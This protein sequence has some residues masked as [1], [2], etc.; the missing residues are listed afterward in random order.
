MKGTHTYG[1][2]KREANGSLANG[3]NRNGNGSHT[4]IGLY[5]T[6]EVTKAFDDRLNFLL[7]NSVG[8]EAVITVTSGARYQGLLTAC[9]PAGANGINV[10]LK[11][12]K[13]VDRSFAADQ[14]ASDLQENLVIKGEDVAEMELPNV[15]FGNDDKVGCLETT[16]DLSKEVS[17]GQVAGLAPVAKRDEKMEVLSAPSETKAGSESEKLAMKPSTDEPLVIASASNSSFEFKTDTDI[18]G[19]KRDVKERKLE[20]WVPDTSESFELSEGLEDNKESWNQFAVNEEKFGIT[21]S[22]DEHLYTTR[23]NKNDP[24]YRDRLKEADR[25]AKDIEAQGMSGNVHLAEERGIF[26]DDSGVDEEDKYSGVD[27]RGDELL[28]QLKMNAKN[29]PAK[30]NKYVPPTLRHQPHNLDPA[31]ISSRTAA[32][33]QPIVT[34][35][36]SK[37]ESTIENKQ[38]SPPKRNQL[39]ELKRFSEKFKVPYDMPEEVKSMFKK[40]EISPKGSHSSLKLNPSLPPKPV[41]LPSVAPTSMGPS[42]SVKTSRGSTPSAPKVELRK[43]T[44]RVTQG[45]T[46]VSSP[47]ATRHTNISRR[48]NIS[49][50]SFLGPKGPQAHR[51]NLTR[52]FNMFIKSKEVFDE[53]RKNQKAD[54]F[55][56]VEKPYFTAPTW[57]S[58]VEQS[59]KTLFPDEHTAMQRSQL[60]MQQRSIHAMSNAGSPHMMALPGMA[61]G[62]PMAGAPNASHNS[63]MLGPSG[64]TGV[65][66]PFQPPGFYPPMMQMMPMG[67]EERTTASP[68]PNAGSPH[69]GT[70]FMNAGPPAASMS[71]FNYPQ[72]MP[73]QPMMGSGSFRQNFQSHPHQHHNNRHR[74]SNH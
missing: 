64:N 10:V 23:I 14:L 52:N 69:A 31:I 61:M 26:V 15:D 66:M 58:N 38:P 17:E 11:G 21:S 24:S 71:P 16:N 70:T 65:Y 30:T 35:R 60:K 32:V 22:F 68:P 18:S 54:E 48:R 40:T 73:F 8:S 29:A 41:N 47:S 37:E 46:P 4:G 49:Q 53:G 72:S 1:G 3:T 55:F 34:T 39:D 7:V 12:A 67:A 51:K 27:R 25:I 62:V 59:Y 45:H 74:G 63:Y 42:R 6:D 36:P 44:G 33:P 13:L 19:S 43:N 2:K 28:A 57:M 56:V 9:S 50:G 20:R 5:E